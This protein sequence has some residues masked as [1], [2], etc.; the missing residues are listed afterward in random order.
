MIRQ[1]HPATLLLLW[2]AAVLLAST[3]SPEVLL[4]LVPAVLLLA[5]G[6]SPSRCRRLIWR[7]RWLLLAV[8]ACLA[9]LTPGQPVSWT[10]MS[11]EGLD[12][13]AEQL[14]RLL[15]VMASVAILLEALEP[16][17]LIAGIRVLAVPLGVFGLDRDRVAVRLDLTLRY[18]EQGGRSRPIRSLADIDALLAVPPEGELPTATASHRQRLALPDV[19]LLAAAALA[20]LVA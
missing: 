1:F 12:A 20:L 14:G 5:F 8:V 9:W 6:F 15:L 13:A 10:G 17:R 11:R 2:G 7:S 16:P 18:L 19:C 3:R 4:W